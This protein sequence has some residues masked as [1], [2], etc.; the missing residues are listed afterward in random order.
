MKTKKVTSI[1]ALFLLLGMGFPSIA[2]AH[3][4]E[5]PFVTDLIAG[6][7][8]PKSA[9]DVGDVL[10]WNDNEYL[11][12]KYTTTDGWVVT[13]THL[14][15]ADSLDGIPQTKKGN[16]IPGQFSCSMIHDPP[17]TE[18]TYVI[19]L[20][21]DP[22][23]SL[24]IA[25]HA[26]TV[27]G[28]TC[29]E[30]TA[31]GGGIEFPGKNWATYF[32]YGVQEYVVRWPKTGRAYVGYEDLTGLGDCDY[33]DFGMNMTV[34]EIYTWEGLFEIYMTFVGRLKLAGYHH[35]IFVEWSDSVTGSYAV[36]YYDENEV[37]L[38]SSVG[39]FQGSVDLL[40]FEDTIDA[41]TGYV[42]K[43]H[44]TLDEPATST[45]P[46]PYDPYMYVYDTGMTW[47]IYDTAWGALKLNDGTWTG[48]DLPYILVVPVDF[49]APPEA[50]AIWNVYTY[51]GDYFVYGSPVDWWNY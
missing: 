37:L 27:S 24:Y 19:P 22:D 33:N 43:V 41:Q 47:H 2:M 42:T 48:A 5:D 44:I 26:R 23:M 18:Y 3:T 17:V 25:A 6:G 21:W 45:L 10:V 9:I 38:G 51:F 16:P 40:V 7:G 50:V 11:Y 31:W 14:A 36:D 29:V 46:P 4:E 12:V 1:L 8:N 30:E 15:V 20:T 28:Y 13:E 34:T 32:N 35:K 39:T 49:V